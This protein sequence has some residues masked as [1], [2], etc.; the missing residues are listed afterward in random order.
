MDVYLFLFP[1]DKTFISIKKIPKN[2]Y[3]NVEIINNDKRTVYKNKQYFC[4]L[5]L[6][7][8]KP[9][10]RKQSLYTCVRNN[11]TLA[12]KTTRGV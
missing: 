2:I 8:M 7:T 12:M 4:E 1:D 6:N 10:L 5:A 3:R 9:K 11:K